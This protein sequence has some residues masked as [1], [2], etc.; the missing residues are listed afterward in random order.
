M[1]IMKKQAKTNKLPK[2]KKEDITPTPLSTTPI[3]DVDIK[4]FKDFVKKLN[5]ATP[6]TNSEQLNNI[7]LEYTNC[8][9]LLGYNTDNEAMVLS[10]TDNILHKNALTELLRKVFFDVAQNDANEETIED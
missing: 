6:K 1:N 9:L 5:I 3:N 2:N 4:A 7:L 8:Y 10:Y